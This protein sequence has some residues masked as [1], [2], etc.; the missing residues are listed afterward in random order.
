M[1]KINWTYTPTTKKETGYEDLPAKFYLDPQNFNLLSVEEQDNLI[2]ELI[3]WIRTKNHFPIYYFNDEGIKEEI[4]KVAKKKDVKVEDGQLVTQSSTG[5]L[6]LDYLFPNLHCA[7]AGYYDGNSMIDR[8]NN[9]KILA[10]C[11]KGY[12]QRYPLNSMRT[13]FFQLGRMLWQ[14]ATNFA[15]MRAKAIYEYAAKPSARIYDYSCG[16]GGRMLGCLASKND[17][18]YIGCEPNTDTYEHLQELGTHIAAAIGTPCHYELHNCCSEDLVLDDNSIDFA[19]S[20]P[21]FFAFERYSEEETQCY[22]KFPLYND[23]LEGYVRPTIRNIYKALKPGCCMATD[24]LDVNWRNVDYHLVAD[25]KRIAVEEGFEFVESIPVLSRSN[26]R[27]KV[28]D[29]PDKM[30]QVYFFKKS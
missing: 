30:E 8:F 17:Y 28:N 29:N 25:W 21:P 24:I 27:K 16:F 20:C 3:S 1:A 23:W 10:Q 9:D 11:L 14:T 6:V 4:L 2:Q 19:F 15:P 26:A 12:M 13:A 7:S 18:Y 22:N 5:L